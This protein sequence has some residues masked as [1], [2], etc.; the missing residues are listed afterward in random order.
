MAPAQPELAGSRH[1]VWKKKHLCRPQPSWEVSGPGGL[2][3]ENLGLACGTRDQKRGEA[4]K[5]PMVGELALLS[6]K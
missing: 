2:G 5:L 3:F 6:G 1:D 4:R